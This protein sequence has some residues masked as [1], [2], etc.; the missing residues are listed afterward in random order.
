MRTTLSEQQMVLLMIANPNVDIPQRVLENAYQTPMGSLMIPF[1]YELSVKRPRWVFRHDASSHEFWRVW[2][3]EGDN[4]PLGKMWLER[5][6]RG[7]NYRYIVA[8]KRIA[9]AMERKQHIATTKTDVAVKTVLKYFYSQTLEEQIEAPLATAHGFF[10]RVHYQHMQDVRPHNHAINDAFSRFIRS[11]IVQDLFR[12]MIADDPVLDQ[13]DRA[14]ARLSG[15]AM[16]TEQL[17]SDLQKGDAVLI[18]RVG[19][20]YVVRRLDN[21]QLHND[22]NLPAELREPFGLLKLVDP[23]HA[24][25]G[26]GA[27]ISE[28]VFVITKEA[29]NGRTTNE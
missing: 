3:Y 5:D 11:D 1:V 26:I 22:T 29:I 12:A 2:I 6:Y 25:D 18:L 8:N 19:G 24:V 17:R 15:L 23:D 14:K 7:N 13:H 10:N 20:E 21:V 27:R 9:A 16:Q 28:D 4:Q